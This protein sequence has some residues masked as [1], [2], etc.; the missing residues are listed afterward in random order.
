MVYTI[1]FN[2]TLNY[3]TPYLADPKAS[4]GKDDLVRALKVS[5]DNA[6]V[7]IVSGNTIE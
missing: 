1:M 4:V 6:L 5:L 2:G 7:E 3:K